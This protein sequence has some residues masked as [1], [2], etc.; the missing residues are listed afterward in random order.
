MPCR[1]CWFRYPVDLVHSSTGGCDGEEEGWHQEESDEEKGREEEERSRQG[2]LIVGSGRVDMPAP[3]RH[4]SSP[5]CGPIERSDN[6][7][8]RH[9][10]IGLA[11][12]W[13][14]RLRPVPLYLRPQHH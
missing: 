8:A 11:L 10:D 3:T 14:A 6:G 2:I 7:N 9:A 13:I 1:S 4:S 12:G 5:P